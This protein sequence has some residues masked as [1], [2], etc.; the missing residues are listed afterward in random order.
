[1]TTE[2]LAFLSPIAS[3]LI[4]WYV[5]YHNIKKDKLRDLKLEEEK[6]RELEK[7]LEKEKESKEKTEARKK[8]TLITMRMIKALGHLSYANSIAIKE[9]KVNGVM[10]EALIYYNK[11]NE[12]LTN[13]LE[14]NA[15]SYY[16]G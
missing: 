3:A 2:F 15:T 4:I 16:I 7:E 10:N 1:M 9:G 6:K 5:Q 11:T 8:E 12:D 14:E 13:F